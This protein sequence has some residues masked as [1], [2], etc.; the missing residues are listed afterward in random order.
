MYGR[1]PV[2]ISKR[3][4]SFVEEI[5]EGFDC[6]F[7]SIHF[8]F[9]ASSAELIVGTF[10]YFVWSRTLLSVR[11]GEQEQRTRARRRRGFIQ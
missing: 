11:F 3:D 2:D 8:A 1:L 10:G 5:L 9:P 7:V 6:L 4:K